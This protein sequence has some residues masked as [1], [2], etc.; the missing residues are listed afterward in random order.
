[1]K[2][3]NHCLVR[4]KFKQL[5]IQEEFYLCNVWQKKFTSSDE[6][7]LFIFLKKYNPN[8]N[9]NVLKGNIRKTD[10]GCLPPCF[11]VLQK[12]ILQTTFISNTWHNAFNSNITPSFPGNF[13]WNLVEEKYKIQWF[14]GGVSPTSIKSV[15][16]NDEE[17]ENNYIKYESDS[18]IYFDSDEE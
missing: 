15:C 5:L 11:R 14:E 10:N 17:G 13:G 9:D 8:K 16:I 3:Q 7:R 2:G 12:K 18:D 4:E 6:A 1:M